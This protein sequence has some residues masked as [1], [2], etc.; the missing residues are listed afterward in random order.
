MHL[1]ET[2]LNLLLYGTPQKSEASFHSK[3]KINTLIA[4]FTKV[5]VHVDL[6]ISVK[7]HDAY[8]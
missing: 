3:I 5:S 4:L 1:L 6:N 8:T 2:L 7:L